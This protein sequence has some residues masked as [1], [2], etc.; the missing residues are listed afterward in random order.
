M[1]EKTDEIRRIEAR[2]EQALAYHSGSLTFQSNDDDHRDAVSDLIANVAIYAH[3]H[4]LPL[5]D[6]VVRGLAHYAAAYMEPMEPDEADDWL[7]EN[8]FPFTGERDFA[9][10]I[11]DQ[12]ITL[13]GKAGRIES[14]EWGI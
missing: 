12:A 13:S 7:R 5:A 6:L 10:Y 1:T 8:L 2:V 9:E 4:E 11:A 3:E 14:P